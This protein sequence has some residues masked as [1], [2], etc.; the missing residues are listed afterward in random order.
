M[1]PV[2]LG[3]GRRQFFWR[4]VLSVLLAKDP[5]AVVRGGVALEVDRAA[6]TLRCLFDL[7]LARQGGTQAE[8]RAGQFRRQC[9][10]PPVLIDG[11][12]VLS[13]GD[14]NLAE[15]SDASWLIAPLSLRE[16]AGTDAQRWSGEGGAGAEGGV[17][18]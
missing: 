8:M 3:V 17:A 2:P 11:P 10:R 1:P 12:V 14:K 15:M 7:P 16:R 6:K 18:S 5:I 9:D 13:R 4:D